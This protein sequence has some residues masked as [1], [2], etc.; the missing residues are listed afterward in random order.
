MCL[1]N[2]ALISSS[3]IYESVFGVRAENGPARAEGSQARMRCTVCQREF[4]SLPALNG[5]MR[6]HGGFRT[7]SA[8]LKAVP[9]TFCRTFF[10]IIVI[11]IINVFYKV[12]LEVAFSKRW[13]TQQIQQ[14]KFSVKIT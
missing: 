7:N 9:A 3:F 12:P 2:V 11:I 5:H 1:Y 4:K 10:I 13:I 14:Y 6:S 8:S